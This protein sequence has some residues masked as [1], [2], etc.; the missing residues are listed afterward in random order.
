MKHRPNKLFIL[1][2]LTIL[3]N[4][5]GLTAQKIPDTN[6]QITTKI[7]FSYLC[8]SNDSVV[9]EANLFVKRDQG[10][11]AIKNAMIDFYAANG[12]EKKAIGTGISDN[13]GRVIK[14]VC[15]KTGIPVDNEGKTIFSADFSGKGKYLSAS[16]SISAK[17]AK[18]IVNFSKV[19]SIR[20]ILVT[21][22]QTEANGTQKPIG[23][24]TVIIS[25]P[26]LFTP[27]KIGEISLDENGNGKLE[28]PGNIVGDSLGNI[29]VVARI[30]ENDVLANVQG[31]STISWGIPKQY[32]LA[33]KPT[34]ELWTPIA[35]I[36]MIVTLITMLTGV[37]AHYFYAIIQLVMIKRS[38][39][40]KK[41]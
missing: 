1:L 8:L 41:I 10:V 34:R 25:V 36:W 35:P 31:Q 12:N 6:K 13:D 30:E 39:R 3:F 23:K 26:R 17:P 18:L 5:S 22:T 16:E 37:W 27:L 14:K 21:G 4:I 32:Y 19:D 7:S 2:F 33:E 38:S 15:S 9:L 11:F 20:Y 28:Y 29:N 24:T 40:Q